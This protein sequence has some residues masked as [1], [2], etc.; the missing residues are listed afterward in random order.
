MSEMTRSSGKMIR[1]VLLIVLALIP[2][3]IAVGLAVYYILCPGEGYFHADCADSIYW[4]NAS[5][6]SG[7]VFDSTFGYAGMLLF[8]A[9]LW[10]MPLI[11]VFGLGITAHNIG[12]VIFVLLFAGSVWF[13]CRS[14]KMGIGWSSAAVCAVILILSSSDKLREIMWGHSI[15]YS[16]GLLLLFTTSG[17]AIRMMKSMESGKNHLPMTFVWGGLLALMCMGTATDDL[18]VVALS[19]F[20]VA[21]ALMAERFFCGRDRLDSPKILPAL[22]VCGI[23]A[24]STALGLKLLSLFKGG[25]TSGYVVGYSGWSRM[26]EWADNAQNFFKQYFSLIGVEVPAEG[27]MFSAESMVSLIRIV[28]GLIIIAVPI[29]M[30]IF[31][32]KI[33]SREIRIILWAHWI[34]TAV[35]MFGFIFGILSNANWRLTPIVGGNVLMTVVGARELCLAGA[36][37]IIKSQDNAENESQALI[38]NE[39]RSK[40]NAKTDAGY[41]LPADSDDPVIRKLASG[42][43]LIRLGAVVLAAVMIGSL[44]SAKEIKEMPADYGR[45][46]IYHQL[47]DFLEVKDLE[48]GYATFWYSQVMTMLSNSKVKVRAVEAEDE[49]GVVADL[50]Q[51]SYRWFLEDGYDR[52]FILLTESEYKSIMYSVSWN[53]W[54]QDCLVE[55]YYYLGYHIFVF[56]KN[57]MS[58]TMEQWGLQGAVSS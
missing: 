54:T 10:L 14:A 39:K 49:R 12:M 8:P 23:C 9:G 18:Q 56:S 3:L 15:Y 2:A 29:V 48:Y 1:K 50:Y 53:T 57:V 13:C 46:N 40:K 45:D 42:R 11:S 6:E 44:I 35:V 36:C 52:Y 55:E 31:Y 17:L 28:V 43:V 47:V 19:V 24:V 25:I 26:S 4:A 37:L 38:K 34:M 32:N 22:T 16:I 41:D 7:A 20:P 33:S 51:S 30:L 21:G 27:T 58:S 5:L